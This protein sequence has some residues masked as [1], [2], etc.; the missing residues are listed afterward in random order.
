MRAVIQRLTPRIFED[1]SYFHDTMAHLWQTLHQLSYTPPQ[2]QTIMDVIVIADLKAWC[3]AALS[4]TPH[5]GMTTYECVELA[6][7][8]LGWIPRTI[9]QLDEVSPDSTCIS[10]CRQLDTFV[11]N[12][13][14]KVGDV[15]TSCVARIETPPDLSVDDILSAWRSAT[16]KS[17]GGRE[18]KDIGQALNVALA[19]ARLAEQWSN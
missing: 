17:S 9:Q 11:L 14:T 5:R 2:K 10:L 15:L 12:Y 16:Q 18:S 8:L 6:R 3:Q 13:L 1:E 7:L 4:K 19:D